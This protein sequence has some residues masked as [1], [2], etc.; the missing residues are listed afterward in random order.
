M[1]TNTDQNIDVGRGAWPAL[2]AKVGLI[3]NEID[4]STIAHTNS[5]EVFE[6]DAP[7]LLIAVGATVTELAVSAG[8]A[9]TIDLG[10]TEDGTEYLS[11]QDPHVA[12]GTELTRAALDC[13]VK[14]T[15]SN[16]ILTVDSA[17][18]TAGKVRVWALV[19]DVAGSEG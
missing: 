11:A 10:D 13:V 4:L 9:G 6:F 19:A 18:F 5:I 3:Q 12:A 14:A 7:V 8:S 16:I 2:G 15:D 1:A 17:T